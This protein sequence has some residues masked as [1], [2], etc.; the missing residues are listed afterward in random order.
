[1]EICSRRGMGRDGSGYISNKV[2]FENTALDFRVNLAGQLFV[3]LTGRVRSPQLRDCAMITPIR[4]PSMS[5]Q[6]VRARKIAVVKG[7]SGVEF[8]V[9]IRAAT[10]ADRDA[11]WNIFREVVAAGDTYAFDPGMS[12]QDALGYWFQENT[13]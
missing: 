3:S 11:I 7:R 13:R 9:E 8:M 1:M 2:R 5:C 10:A 12:R 4:A 6:H